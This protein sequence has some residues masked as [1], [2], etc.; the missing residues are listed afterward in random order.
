MGPGTDPGPF[1]SKLSWN[2]GGSMAETPT[3]TE[4]PVEKKTCEK[5]RLAQPLTQFQH[6]VPGQACVCIRCLKVMGYKIK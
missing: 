5:C 3:P 6:Q 4:T 1:A 2:S